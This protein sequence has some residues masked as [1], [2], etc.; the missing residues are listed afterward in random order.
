[1]KAHK[2][3]KPRRELFAC[4]HCGADVAVGSKVCRECGSEPDTG[5]LDDDAVQASS[6]DLPDGY[7][8]D[9]GDGPLVDRRPR[10]VSITTL[11]LLAVIVAAIALRFWLT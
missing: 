11:L 1:M 8:G 10:W 9:A 6:V 2:R 5:W 7:R 3:L 4:P